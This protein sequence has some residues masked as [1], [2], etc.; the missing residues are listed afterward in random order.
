MVSCMKVPIPLRTILPDLCN[1]G[2]GHYVS[3]RRKRVSC[4]PGKKSGPGSPPPE[5]RPLISPRTPSLRHFA[6]Q[7]KYGLATWSSHGKKP[8]IAL[9]SVAFIWHFLFGLFDSRMK[10]KSITP[11]SMEKHLS[12]SA[13]HE[14]EIMRMEQEDRT[15]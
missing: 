13:R 5:P 1:G 8:S 2:S 15:R 10:K 6:P 7:V 4:P 9:G 12:F 3:K 11:Y 14:D